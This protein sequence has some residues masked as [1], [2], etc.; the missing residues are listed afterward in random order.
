MIRSEFLQTIFIAKKPPENG[1]CGE[2]AVIT[3]CNPFTAGER[4]SDAVETL[5]LRKNLSRRGLK[6]HPVTGASVDGSHQEPGF[7]VWDLV[8]EEALEIGR[9]F[10]QDAI[11][12]V[13]ADGWIDVV[14]CLNG[15][16]RHVGLWSERIRPWKGEF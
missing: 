8:L 13:G 4:S 9:E 2:F 5:R 1:W 15:E 12:W 3:A 10:R 11:F 7:A 6:K 14:S 16:R